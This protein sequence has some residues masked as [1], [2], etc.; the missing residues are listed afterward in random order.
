MSRRIYVE[1]R[2]EGWGTIVLVDSNGRIQQT[3]EGTT[4]PTTVYES[5][6]AYNTEPREIQGVHHE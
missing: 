5:V 4:D 1:Y 2:V 6:R 3:W